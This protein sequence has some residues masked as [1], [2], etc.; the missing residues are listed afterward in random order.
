MANILKVLVILNC[1]FLSA[2]A[3]P[4]SYVDP[5]Y[6]KTSYEDIQRSNK[7]VRT[8]VTAH[9]QRNGAPLPAVNSEVQGHVERTLRASGVF[10][11]TIENAEASIEVTANNIADLE[12]ARAKGFKTGFT[13]Y[14]AGSMV[15]DNYVFTYI[16]RSAEGKEQKYSYAHAIHTAI[17]RTERPAGL[18]PTT[19]ADAFGRVVEDSTLNFVRDLQKDNILSN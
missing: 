7:P 4:Q 6:H 17:G 8:K 16:Y 10:V 5:E 15:D 2:C 14:A 12:T 3:T 11:P 9:F 13:F 18:T 19:I 1:C